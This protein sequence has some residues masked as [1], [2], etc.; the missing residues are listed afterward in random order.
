MNEITTLLNNFLVKSNSSAALVVD[1]K[2]KLVTSVEVEFAD[3]IGAMSAAIASMSEKFLED[4]TKS[5]LKQIYLKSGNGLV[6]G[7]KINSS[8]FLF[9][10]APD[11]S[12]L[13]LLMRLSDETAGELAGISLLK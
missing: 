6:I 13:A 7:N 4:L 2:G 3:C 9:G 10:F 11:G 8:K 1:A 5:P 12:N